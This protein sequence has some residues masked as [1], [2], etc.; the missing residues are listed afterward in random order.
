MG[1]PSEIEHRDPLG[2]EVQGRLAGAGAGAGTGRG[3]HRVVQLGTATFTTSA[4]EIRFYAW[5]IEHFFQLHW[6][7]K[8]YPILNA[9]RAQVQNTCRASAIPVALYN[10]PVQYSGHSVCRPVIEQGHEIDLRPP[11]ARQPPP[12]RDAVGRLSLLAI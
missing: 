8:P 1:G 7:I 9:Y 3:W 10:C 5:D 2:Y 6:S 11:T 12:Q 4:L